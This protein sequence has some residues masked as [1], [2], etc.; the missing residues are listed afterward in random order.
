LKNTNLAYR[1]P[2]ETPKVHAIN[3][4]QVQLITAFG[5]LPSDRTRWS[6]RKKAELA[7]SGELEFAG[8][9]F[10]LLLLFA[11][12]DFVLR[13]RRGRGGADSPGAVIA[14]ALDL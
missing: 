8:V 3:F 4:Q 12:A 5:R 10:V 14:A 13:R 11:A 2:Y 1:V 6:T 7:D 9:C